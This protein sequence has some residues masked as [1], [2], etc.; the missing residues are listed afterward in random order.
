MRPKH[1]E[2]LFIPLLY[3][4]LRR[5]LEL[6]MLLMR[7]EEAKEVEILVLRHQLA[8]LRRQVPRPK[9]E[10]ADR[11]LLAGLSR[12]LPRRRWQAFFVRP[13]TLLGWHR[14][15]VARRWTY[16]GR[17]GRPRRRDELRELVKRLAKE[18][19]TWGYRR[20]AGELRRLGTT[21]APS[22]V[23]AILKEAGVDPAPRRSGMS[24][25]AFLRSHAASIL[26]CDFFTVETALLRRL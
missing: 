2:L 3:W 25:A 6:V 5:T 12:V 19:P 20:I 22:T 11:A 8:V 23:W 26:A 17:R 10:I 18:N 16:S 7:R 13:E 15:L 14:R 4:A 21:V 1:S 9:L 24:W